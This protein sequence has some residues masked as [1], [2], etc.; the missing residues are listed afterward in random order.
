MLD[1]SDVMRV[2]VR[3]QPVQV[4]PHRMESIEGHHGAGQVQAFQELGEMACLVVLHVHLEVI[5][6][7]TAV[8]GRAEQV[9]P[10]AVSA[11]GAAGG[12]AV[13]GHCP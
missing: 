2:L 12:L 11:A 7:V 6:Q 1:D 4:R 13:H 8:L 10:G 9:N 5:Q 3:D